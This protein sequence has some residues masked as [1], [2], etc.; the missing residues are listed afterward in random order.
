M[1]TKVSIKWFMPVLLLG[2]ASCTKIEFVDTP[3]KSS[4]VKNVV[5]HYTAVDEKQ[6]MS[7]FADKHAKVSAHFVITEDEIYQLASLD[8]RTF[9]AGFSYWNGR[10]SINDT[11]IGIELVQEIHCLDASI[12][13]SVYPRQ[14]CA[15]PPFSPDLVDNLIR[16]LDIVYEAYPNVKPTHLVGHQD[17]A[18]TRKSDPGPNFPWQ[19]LNQEGYGAWYEPSDFLEEYQDMAGRKVEVEQFHA[20]L[21]IYGYP[22]VESHEYP[23]VISA[24]QSHFTP[25][26]ITGDVT[27]D[28]V[29]ALLALIKKYYPDKYP[30]AKEN[31]LSI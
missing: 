23:H 16:V 2:L 12:D 18:P 13:T 20:A 7:L 29:A 31:L 6:T 1:V 3:N 14:V 10:T 19:Y 25:N 17:I 4:R 22:E 8:D 15:Y 5:I 28:S 21:R 24:F 26:M 30:T 11:S 27:T 9:H